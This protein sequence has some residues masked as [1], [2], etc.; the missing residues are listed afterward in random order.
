MRYLC[1][2]FTFVSLPVW[3]EMPLTIS[4]KRLS[5]D[6]AL[7]IAQ[8]TLKS[9][10]DSGYQVAVTV[11]D[12]HGQTQVVLRDSLAPELTLFVSQKKAYTANSFNSPTSQLEK[13]FTSPF[14]VPKVE[15]L[16][17]SGGGVPIYAQGSWLGAVGVSGAP[18]GDID[19]ACAQAG[20]DSIID[21]LEM[22]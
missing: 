14:S 3:A 10:R 2:I 5:L 9:C 19:E 12:R 16:L 4:V 20:I 15:Q 11:V 18:G 21:E 1:L 17:I 13:R 8:N 22:E 7:I 6:T